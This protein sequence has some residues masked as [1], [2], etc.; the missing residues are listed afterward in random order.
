[1]VQKQLCFDRSKTENEFGL[2][3]LLSFCLHE[4]Q[5]GFTTPLLFGGKAPQNHRCSCLVA[6][7]HNPMMKEANGSQNS[8][9]L[10]CC[11]HGCHVCFN[12]E[13]KF[14]HELICPWQHVSQSS[15][16]SSGDADMTKKLEPSVNLPMHWLVLLLHSVNNHSLLSKVK[17]QFAAACLQ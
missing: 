12:V 1:M 5:Q 13:A 17:N 15:S 2:A 11:F 16:F 7:L 9:L 3:I 4:M 8:L 10:C 14:H 6:L